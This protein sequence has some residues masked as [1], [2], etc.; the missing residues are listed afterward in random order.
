MQPVLKKIMIF[1]GIGLIVVWLII[2]GIVVIRKFQKLVPRQ[3]IPALPTST[4]LQEIIRTARE[5]A[6]PSRCRFAQSSEMIDDCLFVVA[7][8]EKKIEVCT[9]IQNIN[10]RDRCAGYVALATALATHDLDLCLK[11]TY[12]EYRERCIS[13]LAAEVGTEKTC[14]QF[15]ESADRSLCLDYVYLRDA[16][17]MRDPGACQKI[18]NDELAEECI[19]T[20]PPPSD[21]DGDGLSDQTEEEIGTNPNSADTDQDN[22]SDY[23]E[24]RLLSTK[25]L[26]SDTDSDG[27]D[28]GAERDLGSDPKR[29]DSDNDGLN[30]FDE[31]RRWKTDPKKADTDGDGFSDATEI[32]R[33]YNPLGSGKL[34]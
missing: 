21:F 2:G 5:S 18:D 15:L 26:D 29:K 8:L 7:T 9:Q 20:P 14:N 25:P 13:Q 17:Q 3:S 16:F 11:I 10:Q 12:S 27:L 4:G 22:L 31:V 23:D 28:D 30:D 34:P 19:V 24:V 32:E 33:G 6:D 1:G